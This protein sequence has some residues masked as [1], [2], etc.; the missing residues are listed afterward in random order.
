M[1]KKS[2]L[3]RFL[4][5]ALA[6]LAVIATITFV[7]IEQG[8]SASSGTLEGLGVD[9]LEVRYTVDQDYDSSPWTV[10]S[11]RK[12]KGSLQSKDGGT[13]GTDTHYTTK[14]SIEYEGVFNG[15]MNPKLIF[16]IDFVS[17][18]GTLEFAKQ[19]LTSNY[20]STN[21][22]EYEFTS[23]ARV[24]EFKM[25]S[26]DT[27]DAT[28]LDLTS[29]QCI[30]GKNVNLTF[31]T[32]SDSEMAVSY[33]VNGEK[34]ENDKNLT[35][36]D[37]EYVELETT[38]IE[39]YDFMGWSANGE[40]FST[41][42]KCSSR[43]DSDS[44]IYPL[45]VR[46][47]AAKFTNNGQIFTD[48]NKANES[49]LNSSDKNIVLIAPGGKLDK[50]DYKISKGVTLYLPYS[51][52]QT[53][54]TSE[55]TLFTRST[56]APTLFSQLIL[57]E[58]SSITIEGDG[59]LSIGAVSFAPGGGDNESNRPVGG[60]G[61]LV[62]DAES[63]VLNLESSSKLYCFGYITGNGKVRAKSGSEV[64]EIFQ[65][66]DFRGGDA[67]S[68]IA[69]T[70][71]FAFNQYFVQNCES[72]LILEYGS[73]LVVH[74]S[75][76]M[77]YTTRDVK[78]TFISFSE[79]NEKGGEGVFSIKSGS[80][81][82]TYNTETHRTIYNINGSC[83]MNSVKLKV[84]PTQIDSSEYFLPITNNLTVNVKSGS[85]VTVN[86]KLVFLPGSELN[87][88]EKS[89]VVVSA[90]NILTF[91]DL[92]SWDGNSFA[93]Y[94][95]F[96]TVSYSPSVGETGGKP[97]QNSDI[98]RNNRMKSAEINLNGSIIVED[99]A[100]FYSTIDR[101]E[102]SDN[103]LSEGVGSLYSSIG[104]GNVSFY[105][106]INEK[107]ELDQFKATSKTKSTVNLTLPYFTNGKN[108]EQTNPYTY[109][110][111][112]NDALNGKTVSYDANQEIWILKDAVGL[113]RQI[114]FFKKRTDNEPIITK[115][116]ITGQSF[117]FP[118]EEEL[119]ITFGDFT[120][121]GWTVENY[122]F[123]VDS[124]V[125]TMPVLP[126]NAK[127]F[128]VWGGWIED[129][130][131]LYYLDYNS[132]KENRL[133]GLHR[134]PSRDGR[135]TYIYYFD[136]TTG[137]FKWDYTGIYD[138]SSINEEDNKDGNKYFIQDGVVLETGGFEYYIS[139]VH[140]QRSE[141]V[142][143]NKD[144]TLLTSGTYYVQAKDNDP[145]PS[146]RYTFDENG[147]IVK[148]LPEMV[149]KGKI[150][151]NEDKSGMFIDGIRV[152]YGLFL[153]PDDNYYY[154]SNNDGQIVKEQ[155]FYV[156]KTNDY[157]IAEGLYYFDVEGRLCDQKTLE[158]VVGGAAA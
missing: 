113:E 98:I 71:C 39:G 118:T 155:T 24:L 146:G 120:L 4:M 30:T 74:T 37:T 51:D 50:G 148:E 59:A 129:D 109:F 20:S 128:P 117:T 17:N 28:T 99:N 36:L 47:D 126:N 83:F 143:I 89:S 102:F 125:Q 100:G 40:V 134:V 70:E 130:G 56:T 69:G 87:V 84:G 103:L 16:K 46:S 63:A 82:R 44:V 66:A 78:M 67:T 65:I 90:G 150:Q 154:Y 79:D 38:Q 121:K 96:L 122:Y 57:P 123:S 158:P 6:I 131:E 2:F 62:L 151:M 48:L 22:F 41:E 94:G 5:I 85:D 42:F 111:N 137:A 19:K 72:T 132:S 35:I 49:A 23:D 153:N 55:S 104:S 76:Y 135:A 92:K 11:S 21:D 108:V 101:T 68:S 58:E 75:I 119:K 53:P 10:V 13:C 88:E 80:I 33:L 32:L 138:N 64:H 54:L 116:Y 91:Y 97:D 127:A 8:F 112:E 145:L 142:Y 133:K 18:G 81:I 73:N 93:K 106:S 141:F 14:L 77:L 114:L 156:E 52:S 27:D 9:N 147:F 115:T 140:T 149:T 34:I 60:Y 157:N 31:S 124:P 107:N 152:P 139:D 1:K 144:N 110:S 61:E 7:V 95:D 25:S 136:D 26:N 3:S 43:F 105:G 15:S 29:I 45:Y 12:I 86:Q